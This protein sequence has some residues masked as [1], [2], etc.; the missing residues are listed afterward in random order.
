MPA[1]RVET[2]SAPT[3]QLLVLTVLLGDD[4]L[5]PGEQL[6]GR[7]R[8]GAGECAVSQFVISVGLERDR[9]PGRVQAK[10]PLACGAHG[11][12]EP[13]QGP[14]A[15]RRRKILLLHAIA[16]VETVGD[17]MAVGEDQRGAW[18][19]FSFPEGEQRLLRVRP[20]RHLRNIDVPVGDGLQREVLARHTL[21]GGG[22]LGHR[23]QRGRL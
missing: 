18:I 14:V 5:R 22:E 17:A 9:W 13:E 7:G 23:A 16:Q 3:R 2:F 19:G 10:R 12:V 8:I 6:F 20:H 15:A 11:R 4:L 21:A 1:V